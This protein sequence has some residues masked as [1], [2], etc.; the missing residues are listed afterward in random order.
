LTSSRHSVV[1]PGPPGIG[2]TGNTIKYA[3]K[4]AE[5]L[6][7]IPINLVKERGRRTYEGLSP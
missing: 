4:E 6:G 1:L 5:K 7:R 2:K 3:L